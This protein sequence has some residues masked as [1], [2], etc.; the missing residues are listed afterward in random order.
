MDQTGARGSAIQL[1]R[2]EQEQRRV[3][4]DR[5]DD[6][7]ASHERRNARAGLL[8][9]GESGYP[10]N[11]HYSFSHPP[12]APLVSVPFT[13]EKPPAAPYGRAF[14]FIL[15]RR[16]LDLANS[17]RLQV[18]AITSNRR[19]LDHVVEEARGSLRYHSTTWSIFRRFSRIGDTRL[20]L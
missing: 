19:F 15:P 13:F 11:N 20:S 5:F 14:G 10:A 17:H 1:P 7:P 6:Q 8:K 3:A 12:P 16:L 9:R 18:L 2:V 4:P